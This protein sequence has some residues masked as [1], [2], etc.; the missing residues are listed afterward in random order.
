MSRREIRSSTRSVEE[1]SR[2]RFLVALGA[3]VLGGQPPGFSWVILT[4]P[5][6]DEFCIQGGGV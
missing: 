3:S 5:E 6:G 1:A 4:D 2:R